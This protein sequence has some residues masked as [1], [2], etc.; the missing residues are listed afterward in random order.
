MILHV[1][2]IFLV[3]TSTLWSACVFIINDL[4]HDWHV[5][6]H[7]WWPLPHDHN[8]FSKLETLTIQVA[9]CFQNSEPYHIVHCMCLLQYSADYFT[10]ALIDA[11]AETVTPKVAVSFPSGYIQYVVISLY[12]LLLHLHYL[13]PLPSTSSFPHPYF[14]YFHAFGSHYNTKCHCMFSTMYYDVMHV[15]L[16]TS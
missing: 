5:C 12:R 11:L 9:L 7:N 6:F 15:L 16:Y 4:F 2:G 10:S 13:L 8:V 3:G 1:I 14:L